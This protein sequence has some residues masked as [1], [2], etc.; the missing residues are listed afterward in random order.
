[1]KELSLDLNKMSVDEI[2][3]LVFRVND[4]KSRMICDSQTTYLQ[5][6]NPSFQGM[7]ADSGNHDIL[8]YAFLDA[9]NTSA[10]FGLAMVRVT[11][12][13]HDPSSPLNLTTAAPSYITG[14]CKLPTASDDV[15]LGIGV[16]KHIA[17]G[18]AGSHLFTGE[19]GIEQGQTVD[20]IKKGR[21]WVYVETAVDPT[22]TVYWRY[23]ANVLTKLG[24]FSGTS[25]GGHNTAI[26]TQQARF[27]TD[28]AAAGL[29]VLEV[30]FA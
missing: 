8:S 15:L 22:M 5:V 12:T 2:R 20:L 3:E 4:R 30:M 1:M 7:L 25:D 27:L 21:I 26:A 19:Q 28:T 9:I 10:E 23:S 29:A 6:P 18:T 24:A 14:A 16:H 11:D 13:A 17:P